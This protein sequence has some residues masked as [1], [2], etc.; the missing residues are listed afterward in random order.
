M[1]APD[2]H[3]L[4]HMTIEAEHKLKVKQIDDVEIERGVVFKVEYS[5]RGGTDGGFWADG[6]G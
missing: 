4:V 3:D 2:K 6:R 5:V 1:A